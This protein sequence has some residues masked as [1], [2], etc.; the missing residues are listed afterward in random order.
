LKEE[1]FKV[2][3]T[4][5]EATSRMD[6]NMFAQKVN[7]TPT[8]TIEQLQE[9]AKEGFLHR[10][11]GGYGMTEKGKTALKALTQVPQALGFHFYYGINQPTEFNAL[12]LE[13]FYRFIKQIGADSLEFHLYRG[14]F[15]NW[16]K[17]ICKDT[18]LATK[19]ESIRAAGLKGEELRQELLKAL[20][21]QYGIRDLL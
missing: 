12:S 21:T 20:D 4:I 13:E 16:I 18:G 14:D 10:V 8:Q 1:Q 17:D 6:L 5:S 15:E 11:G 7:L 2:L 9:L 3:K 19:V